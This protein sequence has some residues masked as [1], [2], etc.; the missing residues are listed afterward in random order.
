MGRY[1]GNYDY[2]QRDDYHSEIAKLE[3]DL[4]QAESEAARWR[5]RYERLRERVAKDFPSVRL[6]DEP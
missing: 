4:E 2:Y 3:A 5:E 6:G 1:S